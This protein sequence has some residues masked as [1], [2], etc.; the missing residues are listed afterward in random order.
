MFA[1][2]ITPPPPWYNSALKVFAGI[3]I[4]CA[5]FV[6]MRKKWA[7]YGCVGV[8][9]GVLAISIIANRTFDG[10]SSFILP[11]VLYGVLQIGGE[12][13]GWKQLK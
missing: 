8:S 9:V 2:L 13:S 12:N 11:G 4:V 3:D 1:G 6:F 5:V 10:M 7:F